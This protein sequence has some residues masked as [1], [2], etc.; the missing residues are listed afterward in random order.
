MFPSRLKYVEVFR[1]AWNHFEGFLFREFYNEDI[2]RIYRPNC[3]SATLPGHMSATNQN[4]KD[5]DSVAEGEAPP[6]GKGFWHCVSKMVSNPSSPK[7]IAYEVGKKL[8]DARMVEM[9]I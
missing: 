3:G 9:Q 7:R 5:S 6:P 1:V 8:A 4:E 2:Y